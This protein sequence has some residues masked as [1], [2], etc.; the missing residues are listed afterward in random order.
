MNALVNNYEA[1]YR[2]LRDLI[3]GGATL[4]SSLS[5]MAPALVETLNRDDLTPEQFDAAADEL[6]I[7]LRQVGYNS[8]A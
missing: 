4:A 5:L 7:A 6:I 3:L 1:R 2:A 8:W